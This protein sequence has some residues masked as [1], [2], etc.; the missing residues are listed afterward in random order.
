MD[1]EREIIPL[2]KKIKRYLKRILGLLLFCGILLLTRIFLF[3]VYSIQGNSMYPTLENGSIAFVWKAG[4]AISAKFFGT[5]WAYREPK[6]EKLDLVLFANQEGDLI[7]KRVIGLPGEFYS[8]EA[9]RVVIDSQ[10]LLENYLPQGSFTSEPDNSIFLN[11]KNS[12]FLAMNSQGRIPPGYYLLLGDNREY[13][14]DSRSMGLVPVEK[15]KG[16]VIFY[17]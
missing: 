13:S 6:I 5:P 9:G 17:F 4:F 11:L 1:K 12:P 14:T 8:I 16:K 10:M 15:I 7:V 2:K 3:Q